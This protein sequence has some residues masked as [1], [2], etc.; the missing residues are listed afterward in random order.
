MRYWLHGILALSA[1][2]I[3]VVGYFFS[4]FFLSS[5]PLPPAPDWVNETAFVVGALAALFAPSLLMTLVPVRCPKCGGRAR[6]RCYS[7][8][9]ARR[10]GIAPCFAYGCDS[11]PWCTYYWSPYREELR[12][13]RARPRQPLATPADKT[14]A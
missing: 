14:E 12:R 6:Y 1:T 2:I 10:F 7:L 4:L 3:A 9:G 13:Q 8:F 5:L 11:C